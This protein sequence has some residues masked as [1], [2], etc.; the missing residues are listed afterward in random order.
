MASK[1]SNEKMR[2]AAKIEEL[3]QKNHDLEYRVLQLQDSKEAVSNQLEVLTRKNEQLCKELTEIDRLAEQLEEDKELV[4]DTAEQEIEEAQDAESCKRYLTK[5]ETELEETKREN[6]TFNILLDQLQED[7]NRLST[8]VLK[9]ERA[10]KT[11]ILKAGKGHGMSPSK[12][13]SFVK[14]L[15]EDRDHYKR[16]T[17]NLIKMLRSRGCSP[18]RSPSRSRTR[19]CS[20]T[21]QASNYDLEVMKTIKEREDLQSMLEKYER[22]MS[23]IQANIKVLTAERDKTNLLYDQ[24]QEEIACLRRELMKCSRSPKAGMTA[25]AVLRRVELE[26]EGAI[27][28]LRRMTTERDSLRERLKIAQET[29]IN[30]R[31]HLEQTIEELQLSIRNVEHER[32]DLKSKQ[33]GMKETIASLENEMKLLNRRSMDTEND[34]EM[35]RS[36]SNSLRLMN[37]KTQRALAE[38]QRRLSVKNNELQMAQEK[39]GCFEEKLAELTNL[40]IAHREEISLLKSSV[41]ELDKEKDSLLDNMD[42]KTEKLISLEENLKT[43]EKAVIDLRKIIREMED[44]EKQAKETICIQEEDISRLCQQL[45]ET[46]D[47]LARTGR[48]K[49]SIVKENDRLQDQLSKSKLENQTLGM[50]LKDS[51]KELEDVKLKVQDSNTD[52]SRLE[53]LISCKEKEN[54]ELLEK[55]RRASVQ[56]ETWESKAHEAEA[57]CSSMRLDLLSSESE[58]RRL[59]ERIESLETQIEQSLTTEKSYKSQIPSLNKSIAK[60]E[61]EIRQMKTEKMSLLDDLA[62]TRELCIKLDSSKEVITQQLSTITQDRERVQRDLESACSEIELLTKQLASE[63]I[64]TKNLEC[65]LVSNR[66]KEF[67]SQM[68]TQEMEAEIQLFKEKL[69]LAEN[70]LVNQSREL[71]QLRNKICQQEAE[72]DFSKR[73]LETERFERE[74]AVKELRRQNLSCSFQ[75]STNVSKTLRSSSCSPERSMRGTERLSRSRDRSSERNITAHGYQC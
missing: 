62:S 38:T 40:S 58:R 34:L 44:S 8:Q 25:Q 63:R 42:D 12:L 48:D 75:L 35:Q 19:L 59:K 54:W 53:S 66:E 41:S 13:D 64:S 69:T 70:K 71:T 3:Q 39:I 72:I 20:P 37:D 16:E 67:Q 17:E 45:D 61:E 27:S 50:K 1:N 49:E 36:D 26:K 73:Q 31:A 18:R 21:V 5:A 15:E 46:N 2:M 22:H 9:F 10:G 4:C 28:D 7:K 32:S 24:A 55:Y 33:V 47:E 60:M 43:K 51:Q 29:A 14:T 23:E 65:L 57:D 56:A 30:E 6:Q 11:R 68:T 52:V 74:H